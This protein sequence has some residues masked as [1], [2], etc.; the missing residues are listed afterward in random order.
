[1]KKILFLIHDLGPGGA[2][3]VLVNLVNNMDRSQFDI[4]VMSLFAGGVNEQFL[5]PHIRLINCHKKAIRGNS[6]I[7]TLFSPKLLF[8]HYI[9]EHYD[10]IVSYLEGPCARIVSGNTDKTT[11]TVCWIHIEQHKKER[12]C[13]GFR[14]FDEALGCY[15]S[16]DR[17][18]CVSEYVKK[19]FTSLFGLSAEV[20]YNTVESDVIRNKA[21][22]EIIPALDPERFKLCG[23]GKLLKNKGF[24]RLARIHKRLI[25]DG[26]PVS[27]YILG[28]GTLRSELEGF[29][30]EN[31]IADS[32][33]LLGY[34]TNPYKFVKSCDL[35]VC[36]SLA[37]GFSTAATEALIVGTPVCTVEVSGMKEMLGAKNEYGIVTEN[38]EQALY[39]G[40]KELLDNPSLYE[41]YKKKAA[42]RG[43]DFDTATTVG[44]TSEMLLKL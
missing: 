43:A 25:D 9:K 27:T 2:E 26:Y 23:V 6:H 8:K 39:E 14:S 40:I 44:A 1:M 12:A 31:G 32:F 15:S 28:E 19:D 20:I 5:A 36:A 38:S 7:M 34:N 30:A 10:I 16:F 42:V 37:E 24:D 41:E 33:K 11:R 3:K 29:I 17:I 18:A 4:T 13:K 21:E 22:E 35:F